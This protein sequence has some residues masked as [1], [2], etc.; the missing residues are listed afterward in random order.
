M[1]QQS[2]ICDECNKV[3]VT[4][5]DSKLAGIKS[6][7]NYMD[8]H[9][10]HTIYAQSVLSNLQLGKSTLIRR[11][12]NTDESNNYANTDVIGQLFSVSISSARG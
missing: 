11:R 6:F 4:G 1:Y 7:K 3:A 8:G 5:I 12:I 10:A 9:L 2:I